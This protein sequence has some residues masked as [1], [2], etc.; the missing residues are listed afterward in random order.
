VI[1]A[2]VLVA[3]VGLRYGD[4]DWSIG[5]RWVAMAFY[6]ILV[7][8][9]ALREFRASW[10]L[11]LFWLHAFA[12]LLVHTTAYVLLLRTVV[13]WRNIWFVPLSIAE[14]PILMLVLHS[15]GY[16]ERQETRR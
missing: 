7:F 8:G 2:G 3:A 4:V 5:L 13:E 11:P 15:L 6:T 10:R 9:A 14:C 12:L 1:V 16:R